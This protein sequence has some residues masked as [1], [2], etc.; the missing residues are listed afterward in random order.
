MFETF[1]KN[2]EFFFENLFY[3][4]SIRKEIDKLNTKIDELGKVI[5]ESINL[6]DDQ[7]I[8]INSINEISSKLEKIEE[9]L[10]FT[11]QEVN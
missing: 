3:I 6:N 7:D 5:N 2:L 1:F 11:Q 9:E 8:V 10:A 4:L